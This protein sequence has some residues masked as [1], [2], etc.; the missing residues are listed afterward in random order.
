MGDKPLLKKVEQSEFTHE[1]KLWNCTNLIWWQI[2]F[3]VKI[4]YSSL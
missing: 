3:A 2:V 1:K 4:S